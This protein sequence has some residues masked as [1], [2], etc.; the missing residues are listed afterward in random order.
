MPNLR[1]GRQSSVRLYGTHEV[2]ARFERADAEHEAR[3]L[4]RG[5][6]VEPS[7]GRKRDDR[8]LGPNRRES[9]DEV[10]PCRLRD[11]DRRADPS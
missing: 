10:T 9:G 7:G 4:P 8:R 1:L 5:C 2:L 3:A 11:A 6:L